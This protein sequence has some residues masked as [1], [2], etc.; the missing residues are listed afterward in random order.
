MSLARSNFVILALYSALAV[1]L[2]YPLVLFFSDH[3]AGT[4]IWALDEYSFVW[5]QWW[6]KHA[7]FDLD[8]NPLWT[9]LVFYPLGL[10]LASFTMLW[11]HAVLGLP[12]QLAFGLIPAT[13]ATVLGSFVLGAFGM[14]LLASYLLRNAGFERPHRQFA[15]FAAGVVFAFTSSRMV[16]AAL[17][18]YNILA[19]Q[20]IPLY[21]LFLIKTVASHSEA[22]PADISHRASFKYPL[23]GG[24]F[25]ALTL[26][27]DAGHGPLLVLFTLL[28]LAFKWRSAF[29]LGALARLFVIA[30][31]TV[32]LFLPLLLPLMSEILESGYQMPGWG[33]AENLHVDLFGF[34]ATTGLHPLTRNWTQELDLVRQQISR[35]KDVNT[36]FVGYATA[37]AAL[38]GAIV[39]RKTLRVW[40]AS[41]LVFAALSMGPLLSINGKSTFDLDGLSV[42]FPMPFLLIHYIPFLKENRVPNR[43]S[44]LVVLALA[45]LIG[46]AI[47]WLLG[48]TQGRSGQRLLGRLGGMA[49][50]GVVLAAL[51]VEHLA[52]PLPL[53]DARVPEVYRQIAQEDGDYAILS[54]PLGWRNSFT[55]Q[56]AEDTRTQYYQA[57]HGKYLL[58][59]NT[60]RNAPFLFEYFNRISLFNSISQIELY[61]P[62]SDETMA[63]D[64]S[65]AAAL[66]AFFDIRYVVVNPSPPG[67][68]PF[69]DTREAT[70]SYIRQVMPL[71][72]EIYN[73]DGV[74][75]YRVN[76]APLASSWRI[77]FGTDQAHLFQAEGWDRDEVI[78]GAPA[79][80]ANR[81][82]PRFLLPL[83]VVKD[84][85]L[86]IRA[87]PFTYPE[88]PVQA[89]EI[90]VNGQMVERF[91]L[92]AG[93]EDYVT[94]I[95][96]RL[97]R[98]GINDI[99]LHFNYAVRPR[100]VIPTDFRIGKT[101]ISS[102]VD[103]IVN[104]ADL[105]SIKVAGREVSLLGRGYNVVVVDPKTGAVVKAKVF[106][107][108]DDR[109]QSRAMT[110][111]VGQVANGQIVA[112]ASQEEVAGSLG[113]GTIAALRSIGAQID[114]R[115]NPDRSHALIGVKGAPPGSAI[116]QSS[117]GTSFISVGH[118]PDERTLAAAVSVITIQA[119]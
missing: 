65:E 29:R 15:A 25:A 74:V 52:L 47:A 13:N 44:I 23:L 54:L 113:D 24:L 90:A 95:P 51:V 3:V 98:S 5:S 10:N 33:H 34:F 8:T 84:H 45:V 103:I 16:Y 119:K 116:E 83:R 75:A 49:L 6:I 109:S 71:G 86:T 12:V 11:A 110:D 85:A 80:W 56:G 41:V 9:R 2:T 78:G 97:L 96:A 79:N 82:D 46:Y 73:Q 59:G 87:L 37:L 28:Y 55:T 32:L 35:F 19:T 64:K 40:I 58:S 107:T 104:S 114:I 89:M 106:N 39:F 117:Q 111:F 4:E 118:S 76:Q 88:S 69:A 26:Y 100:D 105:G 60:S 1:A 66:A 63:R 50:A 108:A 36:F 101:E 31:V 112:I 67:R 93:W 7:L 38:A 102:P 72:E 115:Q 43:Y 14:Y 68:L 42:T 17:G 57:G 92:K 77:E 81:S 61:Q 22:H 30:A 99:V 91:E 27:A 53:S 21:V 94:T 48:K 18:H 62:V 20:W 70:L